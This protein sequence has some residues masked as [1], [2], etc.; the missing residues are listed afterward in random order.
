MQ[1]NEAEKEKA[2]MKAL[3]QQAKGN[4]FEYL[5]GIEKHASVVPYRWSSE[6]VMSCVIAH[7]GT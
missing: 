5:A 6:S 7:K 4:F 2:L 1:L 3:L